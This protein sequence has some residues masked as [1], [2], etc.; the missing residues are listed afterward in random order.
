MSKTQV[1]THKFVI[2]DMVHNN[3]FIY[4]VV[5][6]IFDRSKDKFEVKYRLIP[7]YTIDGSYR[8]IMS[9]SKL[10]FLEKVNG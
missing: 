4:Q 9:E 1:F 6:V 2:G 10:K 3:R 8:V 7:F 5:G